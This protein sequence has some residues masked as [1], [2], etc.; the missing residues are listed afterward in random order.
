MTDA[1]I[2]SISAERRFDL[3]VGAITD[4][5]IFMLDSK[6][7]V[8][9]WNFGAERLKGYTA[10]EIIG[11]NY[12]IFF[13]EEDRANDL[14]ARA[15]AIAAEKGRYQVDGWRVR[16]DGSRFWGAI[17]IDAVRD[18]RGELLG[19]AKVTRDIAVGKRV[20]E[21]VFQMVE[22]APNAMVMINA[23]GRIEMVNVQAEQMFGYRPS[24]HPVGVKN[25]GSQS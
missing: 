3:L 8:A 25:S 9:S 22:S 7:T 13:T 17:H 10:D 4:Y 24:N 12:E 6:G 18:D 16:K 20:E 15:L 23:A 2:G 5:A 1:K 14:P 11:R 21:R 19:F